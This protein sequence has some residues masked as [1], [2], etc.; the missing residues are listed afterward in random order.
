MDW[1]AARSCQLLN[2]PYLRAGMAARFCTEATRGSLVFV[3]M[4][5]VL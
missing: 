2:E 5:E 1:L 4:I 3:R